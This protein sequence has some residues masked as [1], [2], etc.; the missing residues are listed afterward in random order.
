[1]FDP[2]NCKVG[3]LVGYVAPRAAGAARPTRRPLETTSHTH[4]LIGVAA[5]PHEAGIC[6]RLRES[7]ID[8]YLP[9][10]FKQQRAGRGKL[11]DVVVPILRPYFFVPAS[12]TDAEF[13]EI[14]H[15]RGVTGF[16]EIEGKPAVM[17]DAQLK[18]VRY[19]EATL[20]Q[21]RRR[22][23]IERGQGDHFM[24]GEAVEVAVGFARMYGVVHS[25]SS[26]RAEVKLDIVLFGREV[27]EV[28]LAHLVRA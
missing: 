8:I 20:E 27:V 10:A 16:L 6:G 21:E 7:G 26:T 9:I 18:R 19:Y 25:V 28:D 15:A 3:D 4:W 5:P 24:V 14:R 12:I 1:M 2:L 23:I 13:V 11:R 22:R 17:G